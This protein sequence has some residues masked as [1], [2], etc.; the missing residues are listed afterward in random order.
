MKYKWHNENSRK[1]L[2]HMLFDLYGS[3]TAVHF[4]RMLNL[5]PETPGQ[6]I[7]DWKRGDDFTASLYQRRIEVE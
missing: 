2:V 1:G 3:E 6:W 4:G 7:S 5:D